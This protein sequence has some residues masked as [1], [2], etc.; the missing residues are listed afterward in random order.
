[1]TNRFF[2]KRREGRVAAAR[3]IVD[4]ALT[5]T[6]YTNP[7]A[8][9]FDR[10]FQSAFSGAA[11]SNFSP[12]ALSVRAIPSNNLNATLRAEFDSRSHALLTISADSSYAMTGLLQTTFG[13]SKTLST[14]ALSPAA[15]PVSTLYHAINTS[16][17]IHTS[18]N[19]YGGTY[20]F[21]YDVL[22]GSM[23]QQRISGYYNAQCCGLAFD[24][25]TYSFGTSTLYGVPSDHRF[26]MSF[27]LA[28]L[29]NFSPFNGGMG[30]VPR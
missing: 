3:E 6:Y 16:T 23:L 15:P 14:P 1:V 27:T 18:D 29:G 28:G 30:G 17:T 2:A 10:S 26:L 7:T 22:R 5:Q 8:S 20:S 11:P 12:I 9:Q 24:Y 19:R 4:V 21:N 25:Q 13:W